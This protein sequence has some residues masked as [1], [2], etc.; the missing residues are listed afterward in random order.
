VWI[1][2]ATFIFAN[3][4]IGIVNRFYA[5]YQ[6][7]LMRH[8]DSRIEAFTNAITNMKFIK[9][10]ALENLFHS[11]IYSKRKEEISDLTKIGVIYS[12]QTFFNW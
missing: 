9:I 2:F 10:K 6:K 8:K 7:Q 12:V 1:V 11:K 3:L 5:K 4:S